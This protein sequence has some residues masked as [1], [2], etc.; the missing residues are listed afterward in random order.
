MGNRG[1]QEAKLQECDF[2]S[3]RHTTIGI[4]YI[5]G[6]WICRKCW[7]RLCKAEARIAELEAENERL[8]AF[9][10]QIEGCD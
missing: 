9:I 6:K 10:N 1:S 7:N 2:C 8:S 3:A 4:Y 5:F